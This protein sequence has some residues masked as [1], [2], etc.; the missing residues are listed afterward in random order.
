[1]VNVDEW[2]FIVLLILLQNKKKYVI[3]ENTSNNEFTLH[4]AFV[5]FF[6]KEA[7]INVPTL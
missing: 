6:H 4:S 2:T 3:L 1:M 7:N 5:I